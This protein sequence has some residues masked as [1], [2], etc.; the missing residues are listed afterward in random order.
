MGARRRLRQTDHKPLSRERLDFWSGQASKDSWEIVNRERQQHRADFEKREAE[1]WMA[2]LG[3]GGVD[4]ADLLQE[5]MKH[6]Q[7]K[8]EL[9]RY[10]RFQESA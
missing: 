7:R 2:I 8:E 10:R 3:K 1:F 4:A 5:E 6:E 9:S